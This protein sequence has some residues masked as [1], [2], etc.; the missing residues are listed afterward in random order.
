L[1][2]VRLLELGNC[3]LSAAD[4]HLVDL[5]RH[6]NR[7]VI[8]EQNQHFGYTCPAQYLLDLGELRV[9]ELRAAHQR[10]GE[11][12]DGALVRIGELGVGAGKDRVDR[13]LQEARGLAFANMRLLT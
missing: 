12:V 1:H 3:A 8:A 5:H 11:S 2:Q 4:R 9:G 10:R 6:G 7:G 13:F